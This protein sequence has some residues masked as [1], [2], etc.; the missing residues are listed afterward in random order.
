MSENW[1][2]WKLSFICFIC[3]A[4]NILDDM[5]AVVHSTLA[6]ET[7]KCY[8]NH[9]FTRVTPVI[10]M[11]PRGWVILLVLTQRPKSHFTFIWVIAPQS[12]L[13]T[14]FAKMYCDP[15]LCPTTVSN[16]QTHR[17]LLWV[18]NVRLYQKHIVCK[19]HFISFLHNSLSRGL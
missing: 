3:P 16:H 2:S 15:H 5:N 1:N 10:D 14:A 6:E 12:M 9:I 18:R 8:L 7:R 4:N 17:L 13:F 19:V 11:A